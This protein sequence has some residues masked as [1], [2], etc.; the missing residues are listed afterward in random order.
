M[1]KY[2]LIL[3]VT[4]ISACG[5]TLPNKTPINAE[6]FELFKQRVDSY[7]EHLPTCLYAKGFLGVS[8]DSCV[9]EGTGTGDGDAMLWSGL[10]CL[11]G[12]SVGCETAQRSFGTDGRAWRSPGRVN[13]DNEDTFS[14][15]MFLGAMAYL[16]ATRDTNTAAKY[17]TWLQGH[18]NRLCL[19][20]CDMTTTTWA[21]M[22]D[23]WQYLDLPRTNKMKNAQYLDELGQLS[24]AI[25]NEGY[26][27]H[28][29]AVNVLIRQ[30]IGK[31]SL[32]WKAVAKTIVDRRPNNPF[33]VYLHLGKSNKVIDLSLEQMPREIPHNRSEWVFERDPDDVESWNN[34]MLWE[35]VMLYN[36]MNK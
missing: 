16:A 9:A 7:R 2:Y 8:K 3:L 15:D 29:V 17:L 36:L 14:R 34:S 1:I 26:S 4:L 22:G 13:N 21:V 18:E 27:L 11:S 30:K 12:D 28:L 10:L 6:N 23:V 20:A 25:F 31:N 35:W 33:F 24:G 5:N 32:A 19:S